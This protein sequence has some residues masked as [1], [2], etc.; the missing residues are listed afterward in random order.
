MLD[1]FCE[2]LQSG[3]DGED[4]QSAEELERVSMSSRIK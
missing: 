4:Q 1:N 3:E 2:G